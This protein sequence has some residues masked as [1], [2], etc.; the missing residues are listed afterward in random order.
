LFSWGSDTPRPLPHRLPFTGSVVS[1]SV[2]LYPFASKS[3][4]NWS[5]NRSANRAEQLAEA[6][7]YSLD[8]LVEDLREACR[9]RWERKPRPIVKPENSIADAVDK[10]IRTASRWGLPAAAPRA[11]GR[12]AALRVVW[13]VCGPEY[14]G[15]RLEL[16]VT[17][18]RQRDRL[19]EFRTRQWELLVRHPVEHSAT[20]E[21]QDPTTLDAEAFG[22]WLAEESDK[23]LAIAHARSS[24]E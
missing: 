17:I 19:I 2:S 3:S 11:R 4:A 14:V 12:M 20:F 24:S 9:A 18:P 16:E 1:G 23:A 21:M 15:P 10:H 13:E 6:A 22:R 8:E 7:K 5:A